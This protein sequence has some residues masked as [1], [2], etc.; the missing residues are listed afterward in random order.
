MRDQLQNVGWAVLSSHEHHHV[1][2]APAHQLRDVA[3][4]KRDLSGIGQDRR[5]V[6]LLEQSRRL[7][8]Q[9]ELPG[10]ELLISS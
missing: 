5:S 4:G 6:E 1:K 8:P 10:S 9:A 3:A 2:I 7:L